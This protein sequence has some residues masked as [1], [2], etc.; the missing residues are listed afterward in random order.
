MKRE[1]FYDS[2]THIPHNIMNKESEFPTTVRCDYCQKP[3]NASELVV[4]EKSFSGIPT[5]HNC[6]LLA[7]R[8]S[9]TGVT[10]I[11]A[12]GYTW[13]ALISVVSALVVVALA[14]GVAG[15]IPPLPIDEQKVLWR[16]QFRSLG[17]GLKCNELPPREASNCIG[18]SVSKLDKYKNE[19]RQELWQEINGEPHPMQFL[20]AFGALPLLILPMKRLRSWLRYERPLYKSRSIVKKSQP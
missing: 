4:I 13:L 6:H 9:P 15:R 20:L 19:A 16:S 3:I 12:R 18:L 8:Y 17:E 5:H 14:L 7:R 1:I 2:T 11:N 10:V